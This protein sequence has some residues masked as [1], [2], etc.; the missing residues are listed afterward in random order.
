MTDSSP[1][2]E[3]EDHADPVAYQQ[4]DITEVTR[5]HS[6]M[7]DYHYADQFVLATN[8]AAAGTPEE[9][10]HAALVEVAGRGGQLIW[11]GL[12]GLRLA[13]RSAPEQVAGWPI[14]E[15]GDTWI[16]LAAPS[17]MLTGN[18][19]VEV[20]AEGVSLVTFIRYERPIGKW[21]WTR[22]S[23]VHRRLAPGLLADAQRVL[24][25]HP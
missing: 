10:A 13:R 23:R 3:A 24:R 17:W 6:T 20:G 4:H 15:R 2:H 11:R 5:A 19:V 8:A 9:W 16:T 21:I 22:A 12:L 1:I 14:V 7:A 25:T 18:L